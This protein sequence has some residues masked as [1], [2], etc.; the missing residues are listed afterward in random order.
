MTDSLLAQAGRRGA[1]RTPAAPAASAASDQIPSEFRDPE[2]GE[3]RVDALVAAYLEL[4]RDLDRLLDL[5]A[6]EDAA[7]DELTAADDAAAGADAPDDDGIAPPHPMIQPDPEINAELRAAGLTRAQMQLVYD[8]AAE[9]MVPAIEE[10]AGAFEAERQH[11]RLVEHFGGEEQWREVAG[12]LAAWGRKTLPK[13]VFEAL[14]TTFE[15][16]L[17]MHRMMA[18]GEPGLGG[19]GAPAPEIG[20]DDLKRLMADPKYW[21]QRD[22]ATIAKVQDGFKRLYP[23][24]AAGG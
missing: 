24:Q 5:P 7:E 21:R 23:G 14:S 16:V 4:E 6:G 17:A 10:L 9:R 11:E 3:V 8:L 13:E 2:T 15:G 18:N 20:E 1:G 22:P 19:A 12:A